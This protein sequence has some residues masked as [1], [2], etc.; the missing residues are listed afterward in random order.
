ME[1]LEAEHG[2]VSAVMDWALANDEI[3]GA[4]RLSGALWHF[5]QRGGHL[6]EG[7]RWLEAVLGRRGS[8]PP[9]MQA[10]A[11]YGL[12]V[13]LWH[14]G[15]YQAAHSA[16]RQSVLLWRARDD[17][18]RLAYGL[19]MLGLTAHDKNSPDSARPHFQ[20]SLALF[21]E[22][23]DPWGLALA[24]FHAGHAAT[25][26]GSGD[27]RERLVQSLELFQAAGNRWGT[28]L[29]LYGL[30]V[31]AYRQEQ[32]DLARTHLEQALAIQREE[33]NNWLVAR[34]LNRLGEVARCEQACERAKDLYQESL[35]HFEALGAEGWVA[36][37]QAGLGRV[38]G[39]Q[40]DIR[41]ALALLERAMAFYRR[42]GHTPG[43]LKC[44]EGVAGIFGSMGRPLLAVRLLSMTDA[45]HRAA[46]TKITP[47]D[48]LDRERHLASLRNQ[49]NDH[50]FALAWGEGQAM[51][52]QQAIDVVRIGYMAVDGPIHGS[53]GK[54]AGQ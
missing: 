43:L 51:S 26:A 37:A 25:V 6:S 23:D 21:R 39:A 4:A 54:L 30:G 15:M 9:A 3:E 52:L 24:L 22:M 20:E 49:F 11:F 13:L 35:E 7:R 41:T 1:L 14:Q 28:T 48:R 38:A 45:M 50:T 16:V 47:V 33:G 44:I 31:W 29:A 2:N 46:Q 17:R 34:T 19:A 27:G 32:F 8:L 12:G 10:Q 18:S 42:T 5:W 40:G 53:G 36:S